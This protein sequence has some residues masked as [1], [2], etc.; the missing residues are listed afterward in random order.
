MLI[1]GSTPQP[2]TIMTT[3]KKAV[4]TTKITTRGLKTSKKPMTQ[5][6]TKAQVTK[7]RLSVTGTEKLNQI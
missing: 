5:T 6:S 2:T 7:R 4:K 3:I 1:A